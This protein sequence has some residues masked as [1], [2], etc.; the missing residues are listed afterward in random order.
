[1]RKHPSRKVK[2]LRHLLGC[3]TIVSKETF[4]SNRDKPE[5]T[6][7]NVASRV[8]CKLMMPEPTAHKLLTL[9]KRGF[10]LQIISLLKVLF[11]SRN[12]SP[13][14]V[15]GIISCKGTIQNDTLYI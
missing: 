6:R 2:N 10:E 3:D 4:G 12:N 5:V 15:S 7:G 1:M 9:F 11:L 13:T 14:K 8:E